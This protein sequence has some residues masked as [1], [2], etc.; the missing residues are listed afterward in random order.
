[1]TE[2]I[3]HGLKDIYRYAWEAKRFQEEADEEVMSDEMNMRAAVAYNMLVRDEMIAPIEDVM[4]RAHAV[5]VIAMNFSD[6][7]PSTPGR[8]RL[9]SRVID[10]ESPAT[11]DSAQSE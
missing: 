1:M 4:T 3:K 5:S 10:S 11:V 6:N 7:P 2:P 9:F 8:V